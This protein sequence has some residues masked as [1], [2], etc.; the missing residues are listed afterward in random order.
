MFD[1]DGNLYILAYVTL[2]TM[3]SE[4]RGKNFKSSAKFTKTTNLISN[5]KII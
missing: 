5:R 2:H 3:K 1:V 4:I